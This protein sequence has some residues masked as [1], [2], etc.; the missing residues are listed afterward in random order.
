VVV[1]TT[2]TGKTTLLL[3][4]WAGFLAR[5]LELYAAGR[6]G[7]PL[8]VLLDCKGGADARRVAD[9]VRRVL[10]AA[11][12]RSTAIWPD[13]ASL[14]LWALPPHQ[15]TSTLIDIMRVITVK[16]IMM[17]GPGLSG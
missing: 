17:L 8:L 9:R 4:L 3:R 6:A 5:A 13:E 7:R 10:R 12:A 16:G 15:L 11:G 1:G 2:G 14:S